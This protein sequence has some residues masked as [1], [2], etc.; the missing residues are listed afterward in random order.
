MDYVNVVEQV[1]PEVSKPTF[2]Q[3]KELV[4]GEFES[5]QEFQQ[6]WQQF[7]AEHEKEIRAL[8][9]EYAAKV[10]VRNQQIQDINQ[11]RKE[12]ID[13]LELMQVKYTRKALFTVLGIP[14][15]RNAVYDADQQLMYADVHF[16]RSSYSKRIQIPLVK[17]IAPAFKQNLENLVFPQITYQIGD[18]AISLEQIQVNFNQHELQ[19]TLTDK[20]YKPESVKIVLKT[21]EFDTED[22]EQKYL[23]NPTINLATIAFVEGRSS[24]QVRGKKFDDQL[25]AKVK[26]KPSAPIDKK[27]WLFILAIEDYAKTD[28]VPYATRS[29]KLFREAAQRR[30]GIDNSHVISLINDGATAGAFKDSLQLLVNNVKKGDSIYFYYSGHGI[31]DT[32]GDAYIL[33]KD[34]IPDFVNKDKELLLAEI[35][36]KLSFSKAENI[37]AF[38]DTCF[39]GKNSN[40]ELLLGGGVAPGLLRT[41]KVA[42]ERQKM[43]I[44]SAGK[45][46][47]YSHSYEEKGHRLFTYFLV[48]EL[49]SD[50]LNTVEGLH[51]KVADLV[52]E[53]SLQTWGLGQHLQDPQIDGNQKIK[54]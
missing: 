42:F 38:I 28:A 11:A 54:I 6:R 31:P 1:P 36:R 34:K 2:K 44:L 47:Q 37:V 33:P 3:Q 24:A 41:N 53:Q 8:E 30:L 51:K 9:Q 10:K 48:Q 46:N 15:L 5:M 17:D 26:A 7:K 22:L 16:S 12:R 40:G 21:G 18:E 13:N 49:L 4:K 43:V 20:Q 29:A 52:Y 39:S 50:S 35:Y 14:A 23:Q 19:A 25:M 45:N 32:N 27:K